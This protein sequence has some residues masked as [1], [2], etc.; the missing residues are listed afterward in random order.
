MGKDA[1]VIA[2]RK[3]NPLATVRT[4]FT[5]TQLA[6][7]F[8][9]DIKNYSSLDASHSDSPIV[10]YIRDSG[11]GSA[12]MFQKLILNKRSPSRNALQVKSQG[13]LLNRLES[14]ANALGYISSGLALG[15]NKLK[16]FSLDG[17]FPT[18]ENVINDK[19]E[20]TRPLL[21]IVKNRPSG[22]VKIF[23][24]YVMSPSVQ[25]LMSANN[26]V[27]AVAVR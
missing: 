20:F 4:N 3:D 23:I 22:I 24:D 16:V 21:M 18:D 12:E 8:S 14:N 6:N 1:V 25:K 27:P 11:A 13:M 2:A 26:Y 9:G 5:K 15:S 10:L 7:I 19:Y 17:I